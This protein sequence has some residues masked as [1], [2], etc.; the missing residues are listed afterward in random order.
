MSN[1]LK[2]CPMCDGE[3][4]PNTITYA[5]GGDEERLNGQ[6][7]FHGVNCIVCGLNSRGIIGS[8]TI[9]EAAERWNRRAAPR[10]RAETGP[11]N[12]CDGCRRGM[13]ME[14]RVHRHTEATRRVAEREDGAFYPEMIACT[15]QLAEL[16]QGSL[17]DDILIVGKAFDDGLFVRSTQDDSDDAW[18]MKFIGPLGAL[19]RLIDF[20][21]SGAS[22]SPAP[23]REALLCQII[24][25]VTGHEWIISTAWDGK[26]FGYVVNEKDGEPDAKGSQHYK[27]RMET[28]APSAIEAGLRA[29]TEKPANG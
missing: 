25:R 12:Q 29:L 15:K 27:Q 7:T 2:P 4:R 26:D 28:F 5:E 11:V 14:H 3:A 24:E 21:H 18:Q 8:L 22:S 20:A 16:P 9:A 10:V 1:T 19:S 23:E 6:R 17:P 13:P